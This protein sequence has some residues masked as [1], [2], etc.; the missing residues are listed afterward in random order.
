MMTI[1]RSCF[2]II[3]GILDEWQI[4]CVAP[5]EITDGQSNED[6]PESQLT[7]AEIENVMSC[8]CEF[9]NPVS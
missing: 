2:N 1:F 6:L 7:L 4:H 8:M 5:E 3:F 9:F